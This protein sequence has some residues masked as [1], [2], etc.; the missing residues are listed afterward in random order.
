MEFGMRRNSGSR[1][2]NSFLFTFI[3]RPFVVFYLTNF[4][5][6]VVMTLVTIVAAAMDVHRQIFGNIKYDLS[7]AVFQVR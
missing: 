1:E 4:I 6:N 5:L 7:W 2:W 3:F